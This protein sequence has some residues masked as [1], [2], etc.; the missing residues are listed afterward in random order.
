MSETSRIQPQLT[1]KVFLDLTTGLFR[2]RLRLDNLAQIKGYRML[3]NKGMNIK[4][5][6]D[7]EGKLIQYEGYYSGKTHQ[8]GL[9]YYFVDEDKNEIEQ[10]PE[11][12]DIEYVGAFPVY[13]DGYN[14]FDFKGL[15]ANNG[16][17]LRATEQSKWYPVI[18][19]SAMD[20]YYDR[21][22]YKL[23]IEARNAT[24]IFV[25][26]A[27][28]QK[29]KRNTFS[30]NKPVPLFLFAGKFDFISVAGNYIINSTISLDKADRLIAEI[31]Q[32]KSIYV[33]NIG[34]EYTDAIYLIHH[35]PVDKMEEGSLWGFSVYPAFGFAGKDFDDMLSQKG[36][37]ICKYLELFAHELAHNYFLTNVMSGNLFWF[38]LESCADYLSL[39][40]VEKKCGREYLVKKLHRYIERV[41]HDEFVP[42]DKISASQQITETYRYYL[43]P[44][45]LKCFELRFGFEKTFR[46]LNSL[47]KLSEKQTLSINHWAEVCSWH[48]MSEKEF[49]D[50]RLDYLSN[51]DFKNTILKEIKMNYP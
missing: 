11:S 41:E 10:L 7:S 44:L 35:E 26:G 15:I 8:E 45:L 47:L 43:G 6:K 40:I 39:D 38:W 37:L 27:A 49:Q 34:I 21:Y 42:L 3:L 33:S 4:Y 24:S 46:I 1:G 17:T 5:V 50:F 25:N 36:E 14:T 22:A 28:P 20:R 19:D 51:D 18:Y 30:S 16:K 2:C 13:D 29:G 12:F 31:E 23:D 9:E 48:G 32:I